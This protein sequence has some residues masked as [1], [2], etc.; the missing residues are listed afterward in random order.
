MSIQLHSTVLTI[1]LPGFE[2]DNIANL[3]N[4][5]DYVGLCNFVELTW[6]NQKCSNTSD[7]M[8]KSHITI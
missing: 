5:L 6:H 3:G 7:I 1:V 4:Q 2:R 8:Y